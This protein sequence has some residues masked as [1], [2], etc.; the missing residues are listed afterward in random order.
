M[1]HRELAVAFEPAERRAAIGL[2][3]IFTFRMLGLFLIL[4]VFALYAHELSGATPLTVGLA[5]GGYGLTQALLQIPL[6]ALS[7]RIGRK[8]V[9]VGG[10][11]MFAFGSLVAAMA[12]TIEG[13]ILGRLLQG[14]GA[15][16][17]A[18]M[19][20]AADLTRETVRTRVMAMIGMS[21]GMAFILA[22]ILG[23][24]L[25]ARI[26]V[27]GIFW[28]I[29]L[30]ALIGVALVLFVVP[31]P[32]HSRMHHD[33]E[34]APEM[35]GRALSDGNLMRLDFGVFVLHMSLTAV[36]LVVPLL[37]RD[38]FG[39][40]TAQHWHLYLPVMLLAMGL[41]IPFIIIAEKRH[42]MKEMYLGG[43]LI[44]GLALLAMYYEVSNYWLFGLV[45]AFFFAAF[46][47]LE[48]VMPSWVS[49]VAAAEMRGT[50]MG[51][52]ATSQFS[53][54]FFGGV[55]GGWVHQRFGLTAVFLFAAA[56]MLLWALLALGLER[57]RHLG[58]FLLP[59][60]GLGEMDLAL[61]RQRLLA[62]PGVE[63]VR[64]IDEDGVAYMKV[65]N[66]LFDSEQAMA[67]VA[68]N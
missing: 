4:P 43:I 6:G 24:L 58:N 39:L 57:P 66:A 44:A 38:R 28:V 36:F 8:P 33:A 56:M 54:A 14:A 18:V 34:P 16:A 35:L 65:D 30:L 60:E 27:S 21:I 40:E 62:L 1:S 59:L 48:A 10:L 26:G 61:L 42:R 15:I 50:A 2:A 51:I 3:A 20:L 52:Y 45:M 25:A 68:A 53:G 46:N 12:S 55:L 32:Q 13:V 9:I 22:L 17:A 7:D 23:P 11:L 49:K 5:I 31:T 63:A 29:A 47:L 64:I 19:A 67:V 41:M 37:L